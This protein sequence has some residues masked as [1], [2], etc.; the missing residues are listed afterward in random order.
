M[1][2]PCIHMMNCLLK[3]Q[4]WTLLL[5]IATADRLSKEYGIKGT[6]LLSYVHSLF[7]PHSFPYDFMHLIWENTI[8]NLILHLD[9]RIQGARIREQA[10]TN[11]QGLLGRDWHAHSIIWLNDPISIWKSSPKHQERSQPC[12]AD[13]WSFWMLYISPILPWRRFDDLKYYK[14]FIL[15]INLLTTCLN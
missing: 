7:F 10:L 6:P 13:M 1:I 11:S 8:K 3:P 5:P 2:F 15:L 9:R 14:H 12:T 4:K